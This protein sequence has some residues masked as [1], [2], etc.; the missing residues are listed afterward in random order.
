MKVLNLTVSGNLP[1]G[2]RLQLYY[3][4]VA[5]QNLTEDLW[6]TIVY[7]NQK[8][9]YDFERR[10]PFW[11]RNLI[12]RK[13]FL[14][15]YLL[16]QCRFYDFVLNRHSSFDPFTFFFARF[17]KNRISIHHSMELTELKLVRLGWRGVTASLI[18]RLAGRHSVKNVCAVVGVTKEI[19]DYEL[20]RISKSANS[21]KPTLIYPNA[22]D[23]SN[24][25]VLPDD[26]SGDYSFVFVC[27]DF[28]DWRGLDLILKNILCEKHIP[29]YKLHLVGLLTDEQTQEVTSLNQALGSDVV[30]PHGKMFGEDLDYLL[31]GTDVGLAS[32]GMFRIGLN[33]ACTLK[34]REYL[35]RGIPVYSNHVDT[36]LPASFK[37]YKKDD[38]FDIKSL[39][40]FARQMR[41]VSRTQVHEESAPLISKEQALGRL[42]HALKKIECPF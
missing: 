15:V 14:W 9:L 7:H 23:L 32:F 36:A 22:I 30:I 11:A 25:L 39:I 28:K 12:G 29:H 17:I 19:A 24:F 1:Q 13:L 31:K 41:L 16:K 18:E 37:Y 38:A 4:N 6:K 20:G 8:P 42:L 2:L 3:E 34:V 10:L 33:E 40:E 26:R 27:S 5:A 35:A 21:Q